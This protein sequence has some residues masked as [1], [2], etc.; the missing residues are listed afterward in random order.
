[1]AKTYILKGQRAL[2]MGKGIEVLTDERVF[3]E[4]IPIAAEKYK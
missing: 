1:M 3:P 2:M 4:K